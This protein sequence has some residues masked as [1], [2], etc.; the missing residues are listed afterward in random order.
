MSRFWLFPFPVVVAVLVTLVG[1]FLMGEFEKNGDV[2]IGM[3]VG[4]TL[5]LVNLALASVVTSNAKG[6]FK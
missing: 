4:V 5:T 1:M 2:A 6:L 3:I